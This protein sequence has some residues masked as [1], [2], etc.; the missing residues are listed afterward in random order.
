MNSII[1][2]PLLINVAVA[3]K[4]HWNLVTDVSN[5][6]KM[7]RQCLQTQNIQ[8][9]YLQDDMERYC[10]FFPNFG[11]NSAKYDSNLKQTFLL[12]LLVN[13]RGIEPLVIKNANQF[14][15]FKLRYVLL[16]KVLNFFGG[17]TS[18]DSFV[19]AYKTSET[20]F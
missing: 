18:L 17:A 1:F 2:S 10:I 3:E 9:I 4:Q 16:R 19:E 8:L 11:C 20:K 6:S 13:E 14:V 12:P 5:E 7:R 15:S